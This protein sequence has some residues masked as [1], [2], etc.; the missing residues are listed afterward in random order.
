MKQFRRGLAYPFRAVA[1]LLLWGWEIVVGD[2]RRT[3]MFSY[4][5]GC[6]PDDL[7]VWIAASIKAGNCRW[8]KGGSKCPE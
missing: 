4:P 6:D 5:T 7:I 1:Y 2:G 8:V 3:M